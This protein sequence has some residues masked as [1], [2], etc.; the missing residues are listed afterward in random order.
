MAM[1]AMM[2]ATRADQWA[3]ERAVVQRPHEEGIR[4]AEQVA[5]QRLHTV[6]AAAS[7]PAAYRGALHAWQTA[8]YN[9]DRALVPVASRTPYI[10]ARSHTI[11]PLAGARGAG[12]SRRGARCG[13]RTRPAPATPT[14]REDGPRADSSRP[15]PF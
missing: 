8:R 1:V 5:W 11:V 14:A 10:G 4:A 3:E 12:G 7:G 2:R 9:L 6:A 15:W 13:T